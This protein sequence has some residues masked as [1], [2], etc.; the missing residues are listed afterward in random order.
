MPRMEALGAIA[1]VIGIAT[2]VIKGGGWIRKKR[3]ER[4]AVMAAQAREALQPT[5]PPYP[6]RFTCRDETEFHPG[7]GYHEGLVFEVF[8]HSNNP[9]SVKGF[10][11]DITMRTQDEWHEY[12]QA[13]H[14]PPYEFPVRLVPHDALDG[15]IDTDA[16][17][18]EI[19]MRGQSD[20]VLEW[21]PYVE[22]A[23]YGK[24]VVEVEKAT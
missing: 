21:R 24:K 12:E 17:A 1:A 10:G 16:L 22:V 14:H 3:V 2:A 23:G 7:S 19:D 6:V 13:R 4:K 11:L 8:N 15:Y 9:V 5:E 18:E 20:C